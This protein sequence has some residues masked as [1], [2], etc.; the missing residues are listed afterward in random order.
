MSDSKI[1][2]LVEQASRESERGGYQRAAELLKEASAI[3][4]DSPLIKEEWQRLQRE[5]SRGPCVRLVKSYVNAKNEADGTEAVRLLG[6]TQLARDVAE[7]AM[8]VL[9]DLSGE[10]HLADRITG[11]LLKTQLH[12]RQYL[13]TQLK[14]HPHVTF[15]R[16]FDRGDES[17]DGLFAVLLDTDSWA[18][19]EK[20][21]QAL[22]DIFMLSLAQMMEAGLAHPERAMKAIARA[23]AA[24]AN[25]L[26]GIIDADGFD[27]ILS[28]LDIR[29]PVSLRSQ[30]TLATAKLLELSP[31]NS[32]KLIT[33]YVTHKVAAP[34]T[35]CLVQ[36]YSAAAA[37]FPIAPAQ[38]SALFL[39]QGFLETYVDTII[40]RG[41]QRLEQ[42]ALELLSA[43]CIDKNCRDAINKH[44]KEWLEDLSRSSSDKNRANKAA[45]IL[46]KIHD[47]PVGDDSAMTSAS[48]DE[49]QDELVSRFKKVVLD[50]DNTVKQESVEG[51]AYSSLKSRVKE[52]LARDKTFLRELVK[53]MSSDGVPKPLIFG[54]ITIFSNLTTYRPVRTDEQKRIAQ[55]KAYANTKKPAPEDPLENDAVVTIRCARV[56]QAGV[57][58]FLVMECRKASPSV[59]SQVLQIFLNLS[60]EQKHRGT[61]AQQGAVK[62]L[63]Q[64]AESVNKTAIHTQSSYCQAN[65]RTAAHALARILISVNPSHIFSASSALPVTSAI[66][67]LVQLLED[68]PTADQRDLLP[69]FESLLALT[70]L[71]SLDDDARDA[72]IKLAWTRIEDLMLANNPLVQRASVELVCNLMAGPRGVALFADGSP[73]A[74][75]RLHI[76]L[77][78]A[79]VE[80]LATRRAAGGALAMLTE[81]SDAVVD[82]VIKRDRGV[83]ILLALASDSGSDELR[84]RGAVCIKNLVVAE[85]EIGQ[86]A[87]EK[88]RE[89]DGEE[90]L[91][92]M[93]VKE[94]STPILQEG[95][96][97][98]KALQ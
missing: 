61:M 92:Q 84:H 39:T 88:V 13:A 89:E 82:A 86:R 93:L 62:A 41:S 52:E 36:A 91:K 72:I 40:T 97:A 68:D 21:I 65:L 38:A 28:S 74:G 22:R 34:T 56:L 95:I 67:P 5:E 58:P 55:L 1:L 69:V 15:E 51:L 57:V 94:K 17:I 44:C 43:A 16:L 14:D 98:L 66:R 18:F 59:L 26:N 19:K 11:A 7:E 87:K 31:E 64:V 78:L 76:L 79:D 50:S 6:N 42:A 83:E 8:T 27:V 37:I 54:G 30:A 25:H 4:A 49:H 2:E 45:L 12:A 29:Q 9:M 70:N 96:E 71:A 20:R 24:E 46:V 81:C 60:K 85:G 10:D 75:Q 63:I 80:D 47:S 32:Q 53:V 23:L 48:E 35:D 33:R 77:A 73:Q 90:V 3:D